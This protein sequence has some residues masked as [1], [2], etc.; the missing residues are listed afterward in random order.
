MV[1]DFHA[2]IAEGAFGSLGVGT[3]W[4]QVVAALGPPEDHTPDVEDNPGFAR[5]GDVAFTLRRGRV[6]VVSLQ[7]DSDPITLPEAL[8]MANFD[9]PHPDVVEVAEWLEARGVAWQRLDALCTD[10]DDLFRTDRGVHLSFRGDI[11]GKVGAADP[12]RY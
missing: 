11:L 6:A 2:L 7:L 12:D 5:Y 9:D 4:D 8:V 3:P 10:L 1:V